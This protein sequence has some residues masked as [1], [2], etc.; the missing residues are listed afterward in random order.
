[1][2]CSPLRAITRKISIACWLVA[3]GLV[4]CLAGRAAAFPE[5]QAAGSL[6]KQGAAAE[7]RDDLEAAYA[8]YHKAFE[9]D[10]G[11][12]RYK[13][14]YE[15]LRV[16]A[17]TLFVSRGEHLEEQSEWKAALLAFM[18]GLEIDPSNERAQQGIRMVQEKLDEPVTAQ[19]E[20]SLSASTMKTLNKLRSPVELKLLSNESITLH[21]SE[22]SK[23]IYQ[24]VAR[25][26]GVNVI[27]DPEYNS[28]RV[29]V[30]LAKVSLED[31]LSIVGTVSNT[32]WRPVTANTIFVAQNSRAKRAE[33][34]QQGIQTFY[35]ANTAQQNDLNDVQTALRNLLQNAKLYAVP[36]QNA[37]VVRA[38]PDELMLAEKLISDLDKARPE[39]VVDVAVLEVSRDKLRN[40]GIQ[41][42]QS[43]TIN[44][45][46]STSSS[47]SSTTT[48]SS[49]SSTSSLTLN[50]LGHLK[51]TN[52]AVT[53]GQAQVEMLLTD[54]DTK[55][56]QN[57]RVR[58]TDGQ[59]AILK[60]GSRIPIAT[61][62]YTAATSSSS[63]GTQ[64]QFQY[65][66]VGVNIDM[67]P[68]IHYD[69][70]VTLK[71]K[72]EVSS[73]SGSTTIS[74]VTEPI[75]S[76]RQLEQ[77]IRLKEGEANIVGG[78]LQRNESLT[79]SGTPGL[80]EIPILKYL[81]S[82]QQREVVDDEIVFLLVPHVVR[83][84]QLTPLNLREIDTGTGSA[85][86]VRSVES[87]DAAGAEPVAAP[88]VPQAAQSN[89]DQTRGATGS[90][91]VSVIGSTA[92]VNKDVRVA[93]SVLGGQDIFSLPLQVQYDS[94]KLTFLG[95]DS[96]YFLGRDGQAVALVNRDDGAGEV[97]ITASRPPGTA[98]VTGSGDICFLRFKA[99][100]VGEAVVESDTSIAQD[101]HQK[102]VRL[103]GA[104]AT[105]HVE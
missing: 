16:T 13:T 25:L 6:Y 77:V 100:A 64:T 19:Q 9:A 12:L 69:R 54:S 40:I 59:Q 37:I 76:Q 27:F 23:V 75:I 48:T 24:T 3:L 102:S 8:F 17:A 61:G 95:V 93:V 105:V 86:E 32:F 46:A 63:S 38:T 55:V 60:I 87:S 50:T 70:D 22:D 78:L 11:N 31:A 68:T 62:S 101:S 36:S 10:P 33:L 14:A 90:L 56:L 26:A 94:T 35:L 45:Q 84:T 44:L 41:L 72:I 66:D 1:M 47:S 82:T 98:G 28:K 73:Q 83:G 103:E 85:V 20:T 2:I 5:K 21:M 88:S 18:R 43:G 57:P 4:L 91:K 67:K 96:G 52:F 30:D 58:A 97:T 74:G 15:R 104:R 99:H 34:E 7:A 39:V 79:V 42:P 92:Q 29:S 80:G 49:S 81:F 89:M 65:I 53:L 51:A 71:L